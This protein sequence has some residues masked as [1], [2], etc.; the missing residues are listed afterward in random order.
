L[1]S[2]HPPPAIYPIDKSQEFLEWGVSFKLCMVG[3]LQAWIGLLISS[4]NIGIDD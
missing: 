3:M 4:E 1:A 2:P